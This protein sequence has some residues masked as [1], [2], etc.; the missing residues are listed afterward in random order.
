[1]SRRF[2]DEARITLKAGDGGNGCISFFRG[3]HIPKG[4]PDGGDGA[5]GGSVYLEGS[6]HHQSLLD[7]R[8]QGV[9]KAKNGEKGRGKQCNG[10]SGDDLI[11]PVPLGTLIKNE[12][13]EVICDMT[14]PNERF[15]AAK[16]GAGGLGN[17]HF[18][19]SVQ[20]APRIATPGELGEEKRVYLELQSLCDVGLVGFPNAGKSSL[21]KAITSANPKVGNY[22]FT[23]IQPEL[24][25]IEADSP[26][27]VADIPGL[28]E[29]A[30]ENLGLGHAFLRHIRR[31]KILIFVLS[32]DDKESLLD[33]MK[34]LQNELRC[35]DPELSEKKYLVAINKMDLLN[36]E[37]Q[38][39]VD[40][41]ELRFPQSLLISA[42]HHQNLD[43]LVSLLKEELSNK[44]VSMVS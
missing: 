21:L 39:Q 10:K 9:F 18:K 1:M 38:E 43:Q 31:S 11:I 35:F 42:K 36:S 12:D 2:I 17:I 23:T 41:I 40:E 22:P 4:G 25:V 20:Q 29:G 28:I 30:H 5:R 13:G 15:L 7:F 32:F 44:K 19:S 33:Q 6:L 27:L 3:P 14:V 34:K 24:G 16:G 8:Y 37:W 26:I